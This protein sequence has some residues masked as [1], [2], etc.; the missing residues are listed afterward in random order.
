MRPKDSGPEVAFGDIAI[1]VSEARLRPTSG[2]GQPGII[3]RWFASIVA[4]GHF[5][6]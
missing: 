1:D 4:E 3:A 2:G 5:Y 6:D